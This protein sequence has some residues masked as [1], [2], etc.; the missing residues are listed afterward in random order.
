MPSHDGTRIGIAAGRKIGNAVQRNRI[1]RLIR[2]SFRLERS[3]FPANAD[4]AIV[5]KRG[6]DP[7]KLQLADV[8]K[9]L[10]IIMHRICRD[11]NALAPSKAA[12]RE[13]RS[14]GKPDAR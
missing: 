3:I 11:V 14:C 4:I 8:Q 5:A 13:D 1:K 10:R 2:E 7:M 6:I 9:D 12:R